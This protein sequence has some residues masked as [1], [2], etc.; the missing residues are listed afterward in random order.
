LETAAKCLGEYSPDLNAGDEKVDHH[1]AA[2]KEGQFILLLCIAMGK[3]KSSQ[4]EGVEERR[5]GIQF[6]H[7]MM[8][9][10]LLLLCVLHC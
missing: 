10:A 4:E 8:T 6:M 3:M 2:A 7:M 5:S 9:E 1:G